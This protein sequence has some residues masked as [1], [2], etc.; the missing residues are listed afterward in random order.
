MMADNNLCV[1]LI[2]SEEAKTKRIWCSGVT[3]SNHGMGVLKLSTSGELSIVN[4]A[5]GNKIFTPNQAGSGSGFFLKLIDNGNLAV[6]NQANENQWDTATNQL[7]SFFNLE[8]TLIS[9]KVLFP[10]RLPF[11]LLLRSHNRHFLAQI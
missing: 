9:N 3:S 5:N 1:F 2:Q 8:S 7:D 6:F 10:A 11:G 4:Q